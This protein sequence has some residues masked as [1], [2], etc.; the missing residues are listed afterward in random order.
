MRQRDI[1]FSL[2]ASHLHMARFSCPT[3]HS[4]LH[5]IAHF[6][7]CIFLTILKVNHLHLVT[8][9]MGGCAAWGGSFAL[10]P[11][12]PVD[13]EHPALQAKLSQS[14]HCLPA[15]SPPALAQLA[16]PPAKKAKMDFLG[17][18]SKKF[19]GQ[20]G[21]RDQ[22]CEGCRHLPLREVHTR[23]VEE[24]PPGVRPPSSKCR[25]HVLSDNKV[26]CH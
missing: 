9:G 26:H 2:E 1:V 3:Q 6:P 17:Q 5:V 10:Q 23:R 13:L 24:A 16:M 8:S 11:V 20:W 19:V 12:C 25:R 7:P 15:P 22:R 4:S 14:L 21:P 18:L